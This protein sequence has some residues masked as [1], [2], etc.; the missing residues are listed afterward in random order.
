VGRKALGLPRAHARWRHR[1]RA[2]ARPSPKDRHEHAHPD[3]HICD[4]CSS[5][6]SHPEAA[7]NAPVLFGLVNGAFVNTYPPEAWNK[8]HLS[9]AHAVMATPNQMRILSHTALSHFSP[10]LRPTFGFHR[11]SWLSGPHV[12]ILRANGQIKSADHA[13]R[14]PPA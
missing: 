7:H 9:Q 10:W 4:T 2:H 13:R 5:L 1:C 12:V 3:W 11:S 8:E 6:L 14:C